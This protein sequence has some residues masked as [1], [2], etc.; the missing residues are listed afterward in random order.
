MRLPKKNPIFFSA[1]YIKYFSTKKFQ[2]FKCGHIYMKDAECAEKN[3]KSIFRFLDNEIWLLMC[4]KLVYFRLISSTKSTVTFLRGG[5][6]E[7]GVCISLYPS[8]GKIP[9]IHF[10][11]EKNRVL[12]MIKFGFYQLRICRP[13]PLIFT[14]ILWKMHNLLNRMKN[15]FS[16]FY[17]LNYREN[18]S[19]IDNF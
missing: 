8:L 13:P 3:E 14:P 15:Q 1:K 4:S 2:N 12:K 16:D 10:D 17:F 18:S 11:D 7:G 9:Q 5:R 19:K 6:G